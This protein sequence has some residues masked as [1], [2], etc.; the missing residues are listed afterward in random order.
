M[1]ELFTQASK[2][3]SSEIEQA[4]IAIGGP[5]ITPQPEPEPQVSEPWY[6]PAVNLWQSVGGGMAKAGF[7]TKDFLFGEPEEGEKSDLR[8]GIEH[9]QEELNDESMV[10]AVASGISQFAVGMLGAGKIMA[11][12]KIAQK[13]LK[14][15]A[16]FEVTRGAAAGAVVIDP[17]EERLSNLVEQ[18]P[19]LSSPV[20][21]YLAASPDDSDA[22]GRFK[23]ALEGIGMDLAIIGV[24]AT[25]MKALKFVKG[26]QPEEAA[27]LMI[28]GHMT[29]EARTAKAQ[30]AA[31]SPANVEVD[32]LVQAETVA[33]AIKAPKKIK[34]QADVTVDD[35][36]GI[37]KGTRNDIKAIDHFGGREEAIAAGYKFGSGAD[38]PW[39]KLTDGDEVNLFVL[40]TT[41]ELEDQLNAMKGGDI[42]SDA[43]VRQ[44]V[45]QRA[46]LFNEDPDLLFGEVAKAGEQANSMV[47][48]M[49]ASYLIANKMFADTYDVAMKV[50]NQLFDDWGG[51]P[52]AA[53]EDL[54]MRL[55]A[56]AS[57]YGNARSM[58]SAAGRSMR[59]MRGQFQISPE[60]LTKV[61]EMDGDKLA[62]LLYQTK[63]D[64]LKMAETMKPSFMQRVLD[65]TTYSLTNSLLWLYP[66]HIVNTTSNMYMMAARPT[67]KLI[68]SLMMGSKGS[69]IRKQAMLEYRYTVGALHDGWENAVEAFKRADSVINPHSSE[70]FDNGSNIQQQ[71]LPWRPIESVSE[72]AHNAYVAAN[73]RTIVGLPTRALGMMDELNK[74]IRY[75]AV[76]QA[77]AHVDG[78]DAGLKEMD[79][80]Q[81]MEKRM[82]EA[83]DDAGRGIDPAALKES[84]VV[85]FTQELLP[86]TLGATTL[87]ARA[88]F[89][90]LH[91]IL[92][93]IKTP[94]NVL[95][96]ATKMT[97]GLN[98]VQKEY[99]MMW[100][101]ALGLEAQAQAYGQMSMGLM[102]MGIAAN[103]AVSGQL[104]GGGPSNINLKRELLNTGWK[105]YSFI[106]T[107]ADGKRTYVPIGRFDPVGMP[108]GMVADLVDMMILHPNTREAEKGM[109][110]VAVALAKNFSEKTF[111][112]NINQ[113][114]RAAS[115]PDQSLEKY[116]GGIG[117][118]AMPLSGLIRAGNPDPYLR[119]ARGIIDNT[120]KNLPGYSETLPPQRDV[121]GNPMAR[122]IGLTTVEDADLVQKEHNRIIEETGQGIGKMSANRSGVDLRDLELS[123]GRNAYDVLQIYVRNDDEGSKG[124]SLNAR[125]EKTI[126]SKGYQKLVDGDGEEK[127]T[128]L[129]TLKRI[130]SK[131]REV[132]FKRLQKD[133][134]EVGRAVASRS[135]EVRAAVQSKRNE[136][137]SGVGQTLEALGIRQ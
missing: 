78:L 17:H 34:L 120:M 109:G 67:E 90:P 137:K 76:V 117:A 54:R 100:S 124:I 131:Y 56:S 81:Y 108:F 10:N 77:R 11:P 19:V 121:F 85:T 13:G 47:A 15:K 86:D 73:Y 4:Q 128:T 9:R 110:A 21:R 114:M 134:P 5:I 87:K 64:P 55:S 50:R 94:V 95:R 42:L 118:S 89:K 75:R 1:D 68:G 26:G 130:M 71:V 69:P 44:M 52:T 74:T 38:L 3:V 2:E 57:M 40:N 27:K 82:L 53:I 133:Y 132:A 126:Q 22:E 35:A 14:A 102:F 8:R 123:D 116:I 61:N 93:F 72:L 49:E 70:Y 111:L 48:N 59:R 45:Q 58:S 31:P 80:K 6:K 33:K 28:D 23:N 65:E 105:P 32:K 63:G 112:Q 113:L 83:F 39:Q 30:V 136:R 101:G 18:F 60:D 88:T 79:L 97:P 7:E 125:L 36:A 96:Y 115:N 12:L 106:H 135:L 62:D 119:D 127:G 37:I 46:R 51:D 129:Y 103:M 98:L 41:A 16:A 104:T 99:R 66:T 84:Q 91:L 107:D 43:R 24:F 20:T 29:P 92:P 122:R 25:S